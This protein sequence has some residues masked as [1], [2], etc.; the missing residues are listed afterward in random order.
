MVTI[1]AAAALGQLPLWW[2]WAP[3]GAVVLY[4]AHPPGH[5]ERLRV[6]AAAHAVNGC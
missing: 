3:L 5:T 1:G 2:A 6:L 4:Y